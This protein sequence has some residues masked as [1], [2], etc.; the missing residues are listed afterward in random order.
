M[1]GRE[2]V[3]RGAGQG[4]ARGGRGE[5]EEGEENKRVMRRGIR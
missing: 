2:R 5:K 1:I 4:E 3:R